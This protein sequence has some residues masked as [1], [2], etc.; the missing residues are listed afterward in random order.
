MKH[1]TDLFAT[2]AHRVKPPVC[3]ALGPPWPVANL[4]KALN[5]VETTCV[6]LD[7]HQTD[8]VRECLTEVGATAETVALPICG[9]YLNDFKRSSSRLPLMPN[10]S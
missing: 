8:R 10:A 3:I 7:L 9:I 4:V 5:G 2:V 6:Q 1:L